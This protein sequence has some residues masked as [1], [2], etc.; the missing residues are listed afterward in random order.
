MIKEQPSSNR[1]GVLIRSRG[2]TKD[3][4]N[5]GMAMRPGSK[6]AAIS[7]PRRDTSE[8]TLVGWWS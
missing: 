8:Q 7:K 6:R 1:T 2:D 4:Y 3:V 5:T